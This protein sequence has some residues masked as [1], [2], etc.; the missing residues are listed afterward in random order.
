MT[1]ALRSQDFR[2]APAEPNPLFTPYRLGDLKLKNRFVLS[3]MTR[4]RGVDGN[5]AHPLAATYYAQRA[6][7]GLVITEATQVSPQG[8]GY[9]RTPGIHS[10][11]QVAGWRAVTGAVHRAGGLIFAQLWHVGRVSHPDFHVGELPVA[12]SAI[13]P[14]GE[15]FTMNG[16]VRIPTPRALETHEIAGIV[17]EFRRAAENAKKAGFDGVE[18]HGANGYLLDQFLRDGSNKRSDAYGGSI[19]NRARFPLEV[20]DAVLS[21]WDAARV[22][23]KVSPNGTVYSMSDTNPLATFG[24]LATELD[25]RGL[26]YLHVTEPVSGAGAVPADKRALPVLGKV[27]THTIIANGGYDARLANAAIANGEADLIAFGVPFLANPDLPERYLKGTP[28]NAPDVATFYAG[29]EKGYVGYP[30]LG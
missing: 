27:F 8:V 24:H 22:G 6:S 25:R 13:A 23:Y 16:K 9:I 5:V 3:P 19:E 20:V 29:E 2:A 7:A 12:P 10:H 4:S 30:A 1:A 14:E 21:V 11:E 17:D 15:A 18:L 26:G 28:L